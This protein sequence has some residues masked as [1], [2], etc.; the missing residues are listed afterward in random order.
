MITNRQ[1]VLPLR[2][3]PDRRDFDP[4]LSGGL[5]GKHCGA[6]VLMNILPSPSSAFFSVNGINAPP[7]H[8]EVDLKRM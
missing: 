3:S 6:L 2:Q 5:C 4:F 7:S 8:L 1:F